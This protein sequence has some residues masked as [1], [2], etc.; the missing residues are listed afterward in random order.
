MKDQGFNHLGLAELLTNAE[1]LFED[2]KVLRKSRK[3]ASAVGLAILNLEE[4]G[5]L[6]MRIGGIGSRRKSS[7]YSQTRSHKLKQ[8][9]AASA[10]I[11]T[12]ASQ[13]IDSILKELG[14]TRTWVKINPNE[15]PN[16]TFMETAE[17]FS[18]I[19]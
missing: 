11:A 14:Y 19:D 6:V 12:M 17:L 9:M 16:D 4:A 7:I 15:D 1:R 3:Y 18:K 10:V 2:A 5:K 13:D 8:R